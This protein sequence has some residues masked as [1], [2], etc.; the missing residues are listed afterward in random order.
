MSVQKIIREEIDSFFKKISEAEQTAHYTKRI[1]DRFLEKDTCEVG[2]ETKQGRPGDYVKAGIYN[3][4]S[5]I[6]NTIIQNTKKIEDKNF[7][8][9]KS[10]AIQIVHIPINANQVE[11][12]SPEVKRF[13]LKNNT[14]LVFLDDTTK[15]YGDEIYAI[16]RD[17][18]IVTSFFA[19]S[20]SLNNIKNKMRVDF[21]V[22]N[23][24][25]AR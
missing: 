19:K 14:P 21:F 18:K 20:Y 6:K 24:D 8:K 25:K 22:K 7:P 12:Y 9:N 1:V 17:N 23:I 2:F 16:I 10:Y 5:E 15:S 11:Y 13:V 4:S 3:I